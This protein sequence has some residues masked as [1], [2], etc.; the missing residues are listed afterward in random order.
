MKYLGPISDPKDLVNKEYVDGQAGGSDHVELTQAE[1]DAL[2]QAEKE[3]GDV[4]FIT[5]GVPEYT[6]INDSVPIGAI[7]SY[8]GVSCPYG[9]LMCD[10]A[11]VSRETYSELFS[12]IG[13]AYGPGD[14]STTFNLPD[15]RG[16][17]LIG[18]STS[19]TLGNNG[20]EATHTLTVSEMPSHNHAGTPLVDN[21]PNFPLVSNP[22]WSGDKTGRTFGSSSDGGGY[23]TSF[24]TN[25]GDQPHNN[26]QPYLVGNYIIKALNTVSSSALEELDPQHILFDMFYPVGSYYETSDATFDPNVQWRGT[27]VLET[28]GLVHIGAGSNYTIGGSGGNKD[29]IIPYHNHT[30]S[31]GAVETRAAFNTGGM[32]ANESHSHTGSKSGGYWIGP[33]TVSGGGAS[34]ATGRTLGITDWGAGYH[35]IE[36]ASVA[37]TH[38]VPAHSH[39]FTQPTISYA[40]TSG[41]TTDANM[42]PYIVVNRW[43]RT[44]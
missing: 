5:D 12:A 43:H 36:S 25:G 1:Y 44:A 33:T 17:V 32:S 10:G 18:K 22:G 41:N 35:I 28:E 24:P 26:M 15:L 30:A 4:Y 42:Q 34:A 39:G 40:G 11:A 3:N 20:G 21:N 6:V 8:A 16:R 9:W 27:W 13:T 29:A 38:S 14:G 37:H 31:D 23:N 2:S 7:Q 19:Y